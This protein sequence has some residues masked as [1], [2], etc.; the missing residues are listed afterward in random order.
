MT[1]SE[2]REYK[3]GKARALAA[4]GPRHVLSPVTPRYVPELGHKDAMRLLRI[5][6]V[7]AKAGGR[8]RHPKAFA[9]INEAMRDVAPCVASVRRG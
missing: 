9:A 3:A 6:T 2:W 4:A 8:K 1:S 5:A 7:G